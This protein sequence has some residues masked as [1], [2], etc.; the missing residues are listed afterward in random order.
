VLSL[1][2]PSSLGKVGNNP[3]S[4]EQGAQVTVQENEVVEV[5]Q[6]HA[7]YNT[8]PPTSGWHYDIP[9]EDIVWGA[10][11]ETVENETQVSYLER[12]SIMVQYNCPPISIDIDGNSDI[13]ECLKLQ[14]QLEQVVNRYPEG[15]IL[16]PY[17]NMDSTIALTSWG[18]IDTFE[19]FSD[20]R[21]DDFIQAHIGNGP[22]SFR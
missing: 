9:L 4:A 21:I 17:P 13:E 22:S 10:S 18:W 20:P 3:A 2:L 1:V 15:V 6:L 14:K 5:E 19:D 16:A 8:T 7:T 11:Q 12:G